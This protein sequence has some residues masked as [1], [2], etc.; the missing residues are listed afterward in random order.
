VIS[1]YRLICSDGATEV[2]CPLLDKKQL[3]DGILI[4]EAGTE[5]TF[6]LLQTNNIVHVNFN[7]IVAKM[8]KVSGYSFRLFRC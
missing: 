7:L 3:D 4:T 8:N 5:R 1:A 6:N 2:E